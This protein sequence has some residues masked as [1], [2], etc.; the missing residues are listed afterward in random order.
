MPE[1]AT[2]LDARAATGADRPA[3]PDPRDPADPPAGRRLS[4]RARLWLPAALA[5]AALLRLPAA[6]ALAQ[7]TGDGGTPTPTLSE[8]PSTGAARPGPVL[9]RSTAPKPKPPVAKGVSP[10]QLQIASA[11]VDAPVEVGT[12][13]ADGVMLDPSGPW[14]VTWYKALSMLGTNAN[15]VMAGHVDYWDVGPAVFQGLPAM[16]QGNPLRVVA[17]D[18]S[19]FDYV[20]EWSQ[21]FTVA[22]LTPEVIASQITGPTGAESLTLI[23]CGGQFDYQAGEYVSRQVLRASLTQRADANGNVV[24][25]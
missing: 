25:S 6:R 2:D 20:T 11:G 12:I 22:D 16:V 4:A 1:N 19:T 7:D 14:V 23:T 10:V 3:A 18:G 24:Q 21:L 9:V 8:V 17:D 15:V 13:S 5:G